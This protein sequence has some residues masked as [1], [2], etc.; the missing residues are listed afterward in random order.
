M[1]NKSIY[2]SERGKQL[3]LGKYEEYLQSFSCKIQREYV[4][5]RFGRTHVLT[6]GKE[7]GKPLFILQGGNCINPV[8]LSW[9]EHLLSK[10]KVYAP[11]TIGHPGYSDETRISAKDE[12]FALWITDLL[13][14]YHI[15]R[16]AFIGPSYGGGVI[17]RLAAFRPQRIACAV[18]AAPAGIS[19]GSKTKMIKEIMMPLLLYKISG[20]KKHLASIA[21]AMSWGSMKAMDRKI[22][23]MIFKYVS[24]EQDMPKLTTKSELKH[25]HSPTLLIAGKTDIFFPED[26]LLKKAVPLFGNLLEW[27]AYDMGHFP[28]SSHIEIINRDIVA[29]LAAHYSSV[30]N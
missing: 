7:D 24:L 14:H 4:P 2:R 17:L 11:D 13:D 1:K 29:F 26:A 25:Y 6:M 16:C 8:T 19:L 5:T 22:I 27:R 30:E 18:L 21:N 9:F 10:Y 20:S 15:E 12:S 28:S 3:I 23:R